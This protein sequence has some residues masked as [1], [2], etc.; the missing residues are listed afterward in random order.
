MTNHTRFVVPMFESERGWG[1]KIDGF[2]GPFSSL[3][4]AVDFQTR[5][6]AKNN[7]ED[8]VPD[9]YIMA[10]DP[11]VFID[12]KCDYKMT[13]GDGK[14]PSTLRAVKPI[15]ITVAERIAKDYGYDQVVIYGR[16]IEGGRPDHITT[17]GRTKALCDAAG[18]ISKTFQRWM[19]WLD[20]D[21]N[22]APDRPAGE[23]PHAKTTVHS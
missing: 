17:Y 1:S 2:A 9:Y 14:D 6:N 19:G 3:D 16:N 20:A 21:G 18:R 23:G 8:R 11:V 22:P 15:P 7:S 13:V 4:A 12:Q 10:L 5:F